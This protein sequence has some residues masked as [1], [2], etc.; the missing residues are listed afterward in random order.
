MLT[1]CDDTH[2]LNAILKQA[3]GNQ[4]GPL[5]AGTMLLTHVLDHVAVVRPKVALRKAQ[6][7]KTYF[8]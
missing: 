4:R 5:L 2:R 3:W 8:C 7:Y 6:A 1:L